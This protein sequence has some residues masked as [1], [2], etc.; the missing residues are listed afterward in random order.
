[1]SQ[2]NA[3]SAPPVPEPA[4][5]SPKISL[6]SWAFSFGPFEQNPWDFDRF[7][8]YAATRGYDGVEINGFRPHPHDSDASPS[9]LKDL[10][11]RIAGL[12]L[13]ISGYA[14]DLRSTPPA[15]VTESEYLKRIASIS[16]FCEALGISTVR[17]DTVTPPSGPV[18][19]G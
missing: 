4:R 9:S 19:V 1:M 17:V 15:E 13:G 6:G 5:P 12:G 7:C 11:N 10:G 3:T 18:D 8:E 16:T 2:A 14:P